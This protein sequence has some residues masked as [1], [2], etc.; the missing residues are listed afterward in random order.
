VWW[1]AGPDD[2]SAALAKV[3]RKASKGT[4]IY[5]TPGRAGTKLVPAVQEQIPDLS[6]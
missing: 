4:L 1:W 3:G 2:L 5:V 6:L